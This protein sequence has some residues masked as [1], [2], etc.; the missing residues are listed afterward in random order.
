MKTKVVRNC[1]SF[2]KR[3]CRTWKSRYS[4]ALT[5]LL[6]F[7]KWIK[8][9]YVFF[10]FLFIKRRPCTA[11]EARDRCRPYT[12]ENG[13]DDYGGQMVSRNKCGAKLPDIHLTVE[14]KTLEKK[15][16]PGN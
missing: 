10:L 7:L 5:G 4:F 1:P 2:H 16:Q 12:D 15:P 8:Q 6:H 11:A 13:L 14:R 3:K 9:Y